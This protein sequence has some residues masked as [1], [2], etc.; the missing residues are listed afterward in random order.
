ME[1]WSKGVLEYWVL[2]P[3]LHTPP[4]QYSIPVFFGSLLLNP[5]SLQISKID[6]ALRSW[7][8]RRDNPAFT[9]ELKHLIE[10][11]QAQFTPFRQNV[12]VRLQVRREY[13]PGDFV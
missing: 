10:R 2:N 9:H 7:D 11:S 12:F 1:C 5:G 4:L 13:L 6:E 8:R 3:S